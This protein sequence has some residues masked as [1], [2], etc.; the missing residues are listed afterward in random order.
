MAL[1]SRLGELVGTQNR[2]FVE[3][4][5]AENE[6]AVSAASLLSL[7]FAVSGD[8]GADQVWYADVIYLPKRR[9]I[10]YLVSIHHSSVER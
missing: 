9:S 6:Q 2:I 1:A 7:P 4:L 10:L 3:L 8:R 5:G